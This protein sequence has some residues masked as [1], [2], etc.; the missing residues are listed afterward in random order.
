MNFKNFTKIFLRQIDD[1]Y[2]G[3]WTDEEYVG[4]I[5]N[6]CNFHMAKILEYMECPQYLRKAYFPVQKSLNFAGIF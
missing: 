5:N 2:S 3:E 1:Y 6:E 4:E